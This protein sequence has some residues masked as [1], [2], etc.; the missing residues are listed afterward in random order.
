MVRLSSFAKYA[1]SAKAAFTSRDAASTQQNLATINAALTKL[2]TIV[3]GYE[4]G[5]LAAS[6][7]S[8]QEA[9]LG[10]D[11]KNG[12]ADAKASEVVSEAETDAII[13]YIRNTLA[14]NIQ[15]CMNALKGKKEQLAASGLQG[16]TLGDIGDMR[17]ET[18]ELG[19]EL[20]KKAPAAKQQDSRNALATV[21]AVF[22][23]AIAFFS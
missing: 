23:D 2:V 14:P 21:D 15:A 12:I 5:L 17:A 6:S 20:V 19:E 16:T 10:Q 11:I 22:A 8:G 4:G 3:N 1:A 7:I 9:A 18:N 13:E